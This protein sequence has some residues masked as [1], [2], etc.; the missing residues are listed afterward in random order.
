MLVKRNIHEKY[1]SIIRMETLYLFKLF[2][3]KG[4]VQ[5]KIN[6]WFSSM[7]VNVF[8]IWIESL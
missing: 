1:T 3:F 2:E 8:Y 4:S 7:E 6:L 5:D